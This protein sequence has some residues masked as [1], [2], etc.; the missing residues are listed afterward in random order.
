MKRFLNEVREF[1]VVEVN[2]NHSLKFRI[3]PLVTPDPALADRELIIGTNDGKRYLLVNIG[4]EIYSISHDDFMY[5]FLKQEREYL[6]SNF[7]DITIP[8][9]H[10]NKISAD[11]RP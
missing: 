1:A 2:N 9:A 11:R 10:S 4:N 5:N 8:T 6:E 3:D 7:G